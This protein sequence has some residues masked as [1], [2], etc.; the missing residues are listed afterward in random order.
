M[1]QLWGRPCTT[2]HRELLEA[3][4]A[5]DQVLHHFGYRPKAG[6]G[7]Y[8]C[9]QITGGSGYSLHAYAKQLIDFIFWTGVAIRMALAVDINPSTNP[10]GSRLVTDMPRAMIEAIEAIRTKGG[11]RVWRWGGDWNDDDVRNDGVYDAMHFEINASPAELAE[12]IDWR[13]VAGST[14]P[15][16]TETV[17]ENREHVSITIVMPSLKLGDKGDPVRRLQQRLKRDCSQSAVTV[18]GAFDAA[19]KE[20][21]NNVKRILKQEDPS[22]VLDGVCGPKVWE[23]LAFV[24][25][26]NVTVE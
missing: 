3:Y 17:F 11:H 23:F 19:T 22:V 26:G 15:A 16:P 12:G 21:V 10:Y 18:N 20:A 13:T 1:R 25:F 14:P 7:S 2:W 8:C 6:T 5:L 24:A 4:K 9:R